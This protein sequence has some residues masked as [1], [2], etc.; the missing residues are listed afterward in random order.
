MVKNKNVFFAPQQAET[1]LFQRE[2]KILEAII[3]Q[4]EKKSKTHLTSTTR[5][6]DAI[7]DLFV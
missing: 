4:K 2:Q 1:Q 5:A 7:E 3:C 6:G